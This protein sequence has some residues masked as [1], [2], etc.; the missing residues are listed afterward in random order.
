MLRNHGYIAHVLMMLY[1]LVV[2]AE[3][4]SA[5]CECVPS[6]LPFFLSFSQKQEL[7]HLSEEEKQQS[8]RQISP[9]W[10]LRERCWCN[11]SW[12]IIK[13]LAIKI[14]EALFIWWNCPWILFMISGRELKSRERIR[15]KVLNDTNKLVNRGF[16]TSYD[17][18]QSITISVDLWQLVH[19]KYPKQ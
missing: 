13:D 4:A 8:G 11:T 12:Q 15:I 18:L 19:H 7:M 9:T 16:Y 1:S 17:L 2:A 6:S 10:V 5:R 14:K 3:Y